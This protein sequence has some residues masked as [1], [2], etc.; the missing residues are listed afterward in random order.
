MGLSMIWMHEGVGVKWVGEWGEGDALPLA[1][2]R[3]VS[4]Y[5]Y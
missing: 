2:M 3:N 5:D 1:S 4:N